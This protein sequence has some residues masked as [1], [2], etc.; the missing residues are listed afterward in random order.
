MQ[1]SLIRVKIPD[2]PEPPHRPAACTRPEHPLMIGALF[3]QSW[4]NHL[5]SIGTLNAFRTTQ[6][7]NAQA[8]F[9]VTEIPCPKP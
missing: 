8:Y 1:N 6:W 2:D 4:V 9:V 3:K 5:L 7:L